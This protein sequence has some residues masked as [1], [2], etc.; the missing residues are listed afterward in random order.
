M[1]HLMHNVVKVFDLKMNVKNTNI[2][3]Q[4]CKLETSK[5]LFVFWIC[6]GLQNFIKIEFKLIKCGVKADIT[7]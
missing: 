2:G 3:M 5:L 6:S 4:V 7:F 1:I